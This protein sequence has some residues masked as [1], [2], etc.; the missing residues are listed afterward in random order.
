MEGPD[1]STSNQTEGPKLVGNTNSVDIEINGFPVKALLDT[2]SSVSVVS[3]SFYNKNLS[4]VQLRPLTE[5]LYIEC[6]NGN[7]L[8]YSGYIEVEINTIEGIQGS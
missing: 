6:A 3:Q 8:P 2:G 5:I 4:Q 1:Q 7:L